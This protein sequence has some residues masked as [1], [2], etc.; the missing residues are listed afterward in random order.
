M[1]ARD[2]ILAAA[3]DLFQQRGFH[4]VGLADILARAEA[5]KGSLYHHFPAGKDALGAAAVAGIAADV[6]AYVV[7]RRAAG[8]SAI[9]IVA[10][11]AEMSARRME[12]ECFGWSPLIAAVAHQTNA[13]TPLLAAAL[14]AAHGD[15]RRELAAAF[16]ADGHAESFAAALAS[17]AVALLE[18]AVLVSRIEANAAALRA[19]ADQIARLAAVEAVRSLDVPDGAS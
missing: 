6:T 2:R 13:E 10:A 19:V 8:A 5:P 17:T 18:G 15:W 3:R 9:Q 4:A 14:A 1:S 16:V 11:L 12:Q 7:Q